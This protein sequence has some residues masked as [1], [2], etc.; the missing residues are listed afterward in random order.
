VEE[1]A[2]AVVVGAVGMVLAAVVAVGPELALEVRL[3]GAG[4]G[5]VVGAPAWEEDGGDE[6]ELPDPAS[7][8]MYC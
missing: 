2:A 6:V 3:A 1:V 5:A 4:A 8:S 7:G